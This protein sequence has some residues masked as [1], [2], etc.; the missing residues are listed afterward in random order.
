MQQE[1]GLLAT[2][3]ARLAAR[4]DQVFWPIF[5][6]PFAHIHKL[7]Q[8]GHLYRNVFESP[9]LTALHS[10]RV[11]L[12]SH[13]PSA[14]KVQ[15]EKEKPGAS[16]FTYKASVVLEGIHSAGHAGH[17]EM[18]SSVTSLVNPVQ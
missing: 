3:E 13:P 12:R 15:G 2:R 5:H 9:F 8:L 18:T 14:T 17:G 1:L 11:T 6:S 7:C 16:A 10:E 4:L